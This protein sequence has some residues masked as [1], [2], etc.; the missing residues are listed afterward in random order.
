M[1]FDWCRWQLIQLLW[2]DIR[3]ID[4]N[5]FARRLILFVFDAGCVQHAFRCDHFGFMCMFIRQIDDFSH[6]RLDDNFGAFIAR[7]QCHIQCTIF[8]IGRQF[9]EHGIDFSMAHVHV[10]RVQTIGRIFI[11]WKFIIAATV[12]KSIVANADDLP[13]F[14]Y[15][16]CTNL[17]TWIFAPFGCQKCH[18]HEVI[19]PW[20]VIVSL[21][22]WIHGLMSLDMVLLWWCWWLL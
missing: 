8:Q 20:Y 15:D 2:I 7:K 21:L 19:V 10:F 9:I 3:E 18:R 14:V 13:V 4:D 16:A 5:T 11:P 22:W 1:W 17:C 6:T 12:R